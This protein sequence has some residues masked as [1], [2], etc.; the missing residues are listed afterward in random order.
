MKKVIV[1]LIIF[2]N[3]SLILNYAEAQ[4]ERAQLIAAYINNFIKYTEW[5]EEDKLNSYNI[6]VFTDDS[7]IKKQFQELASRK[8]VKRKKISVNFYSRIAPLQS[9]Q[10]VFVAKDKLNYLIELYD[11]IEGKPILLVSEEYPDKRIIMINLFSTVQNK[12]GFE[13]NKANIL[14]QNLNI[15][16]EILLIGGTEIDV[17]ALYRKSQVTLRSM[18]KD[19]ERLQDSIK[20]LQAGID[21]SIRMIEEQKVEIE[22]QKLLIN[23]INEQIKLQQQLLAE[24]ENFLL[25]QKDSIR[26]KDAFLKSQQE[27]I[28]NNL[29]ENKKLEAQL[30]ER[31]ENIEK[32][33]QEITLKN[34]ELGTKTETIEKQ[35]Q[36]LMLFYLI[37]F[38]VLILIVTVTFALINN[39]KKNKILISQTKLI[40]EKL[41]QLEELNEKLKRAD[42][43]KS[44][45]LASMSHELRTP[46]NSIIGY[47]GILLMGMTGK[48]N[49]EQV[50]QLTK[51]KNN[52][53]HLLSLI[54]DI[55]DISKIESG[56][57]ELAIEEFKVNDL[58]N[59]IVEIIFP[60]ASEKSLKI[61][62]DQPEE[63]FIKTDKRRLKQVILN[64]ASNAVNYTDEGS[65]D[66]KLQRVGADTVRISVKDTGIGIPEEDMKRLFQPFQQIDSSLTKKNKGTGL[67]LYLCRKLITLLNGK[68]YLISEVGVGS[69]FFVE[70]PINK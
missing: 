24:Q 27:L 61:N 44:I 38:L 36:I 54:N 30:N 35:K 69:E 40:E 48:L 49:E 56:K 26:S 10:L 45:F 12:M 21:N 46:L 55:L 2:I 7:E 37:G 25:L 41:K 1:Y 70:L 39:R 16:P 11:L 23:E 3:Y 29:E 47:T 31:L 62:V 66:I 33:N 13:V 65:I 6:A 59:E 14:N 63:I 5:P 52:A 67:G 34:K 43:Y 17:A 28:K 22:K 42:Q 50:K 57:I 15:D 8:L 18:Q 68:I 51:V 9:F 20:T 60:K 4:V 64:L 32:L 58:I 53:K 19:M